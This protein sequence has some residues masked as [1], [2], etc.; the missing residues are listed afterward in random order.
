MPCRSLGEGGY[1]IRLESSELFCLKK[2]KPAR[3]SVSGF[4][5]KKTAPLH[6]CG[7]YA[8][9]YIGILLTHCTLLGTDIRGIY[10]QTSLSVNTLT[11][12]TMRTVSAR[13]FVNQ[14][15]SFGV[16]AS[17]LSSDKRLSINTISEHR[18]ISIVF[19]IGN[20]FAPIF[21]FPAMKRLSGRDAQ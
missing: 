14:G 5:Y 20:F 11:R 1:L 13:I 18:R 15:K 10:P 7:W 2:I 8:G 6:E 16:F 21:L 9:A 3:L 19:S 12:P 4:F 17:F